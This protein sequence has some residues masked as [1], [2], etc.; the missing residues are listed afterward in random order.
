MTD[1]SIIPGVRA[2]CI[3]LLAA[4]A[5]ALGGAGA[6]AQDPAIPGDVAFEQK[7]GA[8]VPLDLMLHGEQGDPVRLGDL[9]GPRPV[10]LALVY[11]RC[12]RLCGLVLEGLLRSLRAVSLEA[13]KDFKVA[14]VSIDPREPP[15][16]GAA[17]KEECLQA[18]ARPGAESGWR[19]LGGEEAALRS[20][21]DS[22]GFRY[23]YDPLTDQYA[24]AAG[25]V[26]LTPEGKAARYLAGV[27]YAPRDVRLALV[28]A[29]AGK[30]GS[31]VDQVFLLCFAWDPATG[32]YGLVIHRVLM[33]ACGATVVVLGFYVAS[34]LRRERRHA[35]AEKGG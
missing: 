2:A 20:L 29:S 30:I 15:S 6:L 10:I 13:G 16:L 8:Q 22:V 7:L 3:G 25:I 14:V 33:L 26:I 21:A 23:R 24:H 12:P 19:F 17:R 32:K 34:T 11:H 18:Y 4:W 27:E 9:F 31:P 28:E 1:G 5:L 35:R